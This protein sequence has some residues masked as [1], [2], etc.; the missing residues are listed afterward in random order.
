MSQN[1]YFPAL[2]RVPFFS[3]LPS[4]ELQLLAENATIVRMPA[5]SRIAREGDIGDRMWILQSG[6]VQIYTTSF[7]GSDLVLARVEAGQ[8]FGEQALIPGGT[9]RRT[10]SVRVLEDCALLELRRSAVAKVI[11]ENRGALARLHEERET[12][13]IARDEK[14]RD[15]IFSSLGVVARGETYRL[16]AYSSGQQIFREGDP[17][18]RVYLL[19][20]GMAVVRRGAETLAELM[21]GQFFG[22]LAILNN[23]PR[24]A[25]VEAV[26]EIEVA[27]LDGEWFRSAHRESPV[28]KG[29]MESLSDIYLMPHRGLL[30]LQIGRMDNE[31]ALT[32]IYHLPDGRRAVC[33]RLAQHDTFAASV[34]GQSASAETV[35]FICPERGLRRE[36][37]IAD[38]RVIGINC[39]GEWVRLGKVLEMLLDGTPI[40]EWQVAM[41][42]EKGNFQAEAPKPLYEEGEVLCAC[43]KASCG[44]LMTAIAEG[45]HT[46]DAVAARTGATRVC[47]GC[48]PLVKELLGRGDW[49]PARVAETI[50][51]SEDIRT[52]RI[53][54]LEGN[55]RPWLPGQHLILQA[56]IENRWVQ[57][58]YTLSSVSGTDNLYEITVKREP[59]GVLSRWL[60]DRLTPHA[61]LRVSEPAGDYCLSD[62]QAED[63]VCFVG[64]IGLTPALAMAR[65]LVKQPRNFH[66]H[67]DY[68]VSEEN[69]QILT[70][71]LRTFASKNP[72]ISVQTRVT[73]RDGRLSH[74]EV[75]AVVSR[76]PKATFFLCGGTKFM[77]A[78]RSY[79]T[80]SGVPNER[81]RVE[82]FTVAGEK[83]LTQPVAQKCPADHQIAE[84]AEQPQSPIDQA[85]TMLRQYYTEVNALPV[86]ERR[87]K[88]V[89]EE[90][91]LKGTYTQTTE[92]LGYLAKVAW[93]N[94][95]R[96]IGR[97]YWE[98]IALRD[99]RHA[100]TGEEMLDAIMGHIE[101]ATNRGNLR[102][103][104]TIFRP[105]DSDG[106]G[107]RVWSPQLF[108]YAAY[109]AADGSIIGDPANLELTEVCQAL[110][111]Q[112]P[113]KRG[114]F[115]LLPIIVQSEPNRPPAWREIPKH[116]VLEA[117]ITH[118]EYAWF[119]S[120]GLKW[121]ALPAVSSM[122]L[123]AAGLVYT[124]APFNGWY[125]G[126]EIGARNFGDTYRYNL[127][128]I[129][130]EKLGLDTSTDRTLWRDRAL[131]ELNIAVLHSY[132][133]AGITMMDHHA[134]SHSFDKFEQ[135]E[136]A[137]GR[138]V[139]ARWNWLVPPISGSAVTVFH[140]DSWKDIQLKPCYA[141]Q[142]DPWKTDLCWK[143]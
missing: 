32:A 50:P 5:G 82:I 97:M 17:G 61:M 113:T 107:P 47:G 54:P 24:N 9:G 141:H 45:C 15:A 76:H 12:Q 130:A 128:K 42:Q 40:E 60:F 94:S 2:R 29:L 127:L 90:F 114:H 39:V 129:V 63:V 125:M 28:L 84:V 135:L 117:E 103:A 75:K 4:E 1:D 115:D 72:K 27:S 34:L 38:Q 20:K 53:A 56:R 105:A 16:E 73:K 8:Y 7:D 41:F 37:R 122:A 22:E 64:G 89:A 110:G 133:K 85:E 30:T 71:E 3:Q 124:A 51:L 79:L 77:D 118:P 112:P 121:Y 62:A 66:L 116:L 31:P 99:F 81:I 80:E 92:E 104:I 25:T 119:A 109:K 78:A 59:N 96:C 26:G 83:P 123:D 139:Y 18:E 98:G 70:D 87:W 108:R 100:K 68:S 55:C 43:T 134:A 44:Q 102:P 143:V 95:T 120:L 69:Q 11:E 21:P 46:V 86:F 140:R 52:F 33:T 57:R 111:W 19:L 126:T 10:A 74:D 137:A 65:A 136:I 142:P 13:R 23:S 132:E 106:N 48:T 49:T 67:I 88:Q 14:L 91:R 58:A 36:I 6:V 101:F 138:T 93:R 131:I 35:S